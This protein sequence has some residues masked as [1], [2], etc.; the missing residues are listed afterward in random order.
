MCCLYQKTDSPKQEYIYISHNAIPL[1]LS[2][3]RV[4]DLEALVLNYDSGACGLRFGTKVLLFL[5]VCDVLQ[6]YFRKA[7]D[8][9]EGF[10]QSHKT[11]LEAK[12]RRGVRGLVPKGFPYI[13]VDFS[14][15]KSSVSV[16]SA[17]F[18]RN[19][20]PKPCS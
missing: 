9:S 1:H 10:W 15:G 14:L 12:G 13:Y 11:V 19:P 20:D 4:L 3:F 16:S 2:G 8:E 17:M 6:S 7:F 5:C 18:Y